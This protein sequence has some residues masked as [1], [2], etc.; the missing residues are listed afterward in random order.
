M[1]F[2]GSWDGWTFLLGVSVCLLVLLAVRLARGKMELQATMSVKAYYAQRA[3]LVLLIVLVG[4]QG[5]LLISRSGKQDQQGRAGERQ[6]NAEESIPPEAGETD[7][8]ESA[9]A[10]DARHDTKE[11]R[12]ETTIL[13][14][15]LWLNLCLASPW[16]T[17]YVI[18]WVLEKRSNVA[19]FVLLTAYTILDLILGMSVA[20]FRFA[21]GIGAMMLIALL[22]LCSGYNYW[23]GETIAGMW[24]RSPRGR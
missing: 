18:R 24:V 6:P 21:G 2:S 17:A 9:F 10:Q 19:S 23:A 14:F 20:H 8:V 4:F 7:T 11:G 1:Q 22:V 16:I 12:S 13:R 3:L 15:I 5:W